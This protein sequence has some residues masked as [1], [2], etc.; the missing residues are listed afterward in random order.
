MDNDVNAR[1]R[2]SSVAFDEG[3]EVSTV[4]M[5]VSTGTLEAIKAFVPEATWTVRSETENE[6]TLLVQDMLTLF[7]HAGRT[8]GLDPRYPHTSQIYDSLTMVVYGLMEDD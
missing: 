8:S 5:I 2:V 6:V 7:R 1:C 4:T 3:Q